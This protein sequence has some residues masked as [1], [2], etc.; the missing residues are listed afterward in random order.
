MSDDKVMDGKRLLCP[1]CGATLDDSGGEIV[2]K[3]CSASWQGLDSLRSEMVQ[4]AQAVSP[5]VSRLKPRIIFQIVLVALSLAVTALGFIYIIPVFPQ[6]N[7]STVP[8]Y[9][10]VLLWS[11]IVAIC[12]IPLIFAFAT[13]QTILLL[14]RMLKMEKSLRQNPLQ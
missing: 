8:L 2:C 9:E 4:K 1:H 3:A 14:R 5:L 12:L 11:F 6:L 10:R 7:A 13:V